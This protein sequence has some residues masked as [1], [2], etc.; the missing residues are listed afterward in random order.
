MTG[1]TK[2][3]KSDALTGTPLSKTSGVAV[4][5]VAAAVVVTAAVLFT[6]KRQIAKSRSSVMPMIEPPEYANEG[7]TDANI[8]AELTEDKVIEGR[9]ATG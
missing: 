7:A 4:V 5:A 8:A 1:K 3:S 9:A 2:K 6:I